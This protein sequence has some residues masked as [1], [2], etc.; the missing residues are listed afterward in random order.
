MKIIKTFTALSLSAL[1]AFSA[2]A[3]VSAA[4]D[5][6]YAGAQVINVSAADLRDGAQWAIQSA[7]D[8]A[9][10]QAT[11]S[12]PVTVKAAAGS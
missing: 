1:I 7:L 3:A 4:E 12:N 10:N 5:D 2:A 9:K 6:S 11:A 8:K